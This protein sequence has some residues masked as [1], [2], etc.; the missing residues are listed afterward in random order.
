MS[1]GLVSDTGSQ[2]PTPAVEPERGFLQNLSDVFFAPTEGFKAIARQ[3]RWVTP[4]IV[5]IAMGL[6]STAVWTAK[7][8]P[9]EFFKAQLEESRRTAELPADQKDKIVEAQAPWLKPMAWAGALVGAPLW[10][11][12]LGAYFLFAFRFMYGVSA[13]TFKQSFTISAFC[14]L[15]VSLVQTPV[16]FATLALKGDWNL[17]P[18]LAF[19]ASPAMFLDRMETAKWLY[20]LASSFDLFTLWSLA[21][22]A[23]GFGV[24][25]KRS[26]GSA[27][28]AAVIP[29]LIIVLIKAGFAAMFP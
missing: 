14:S 25:T 21:L 29:W 16:T 28:W 17:N 1:S 5:A 2:A 12:I 13:L 10:F 27:A 26:A 9:R 23:L 15:A 18:Q 8:E 6:A 3:P 20:A 11:L 24:A 19:Q 22:L 4:L 7:V